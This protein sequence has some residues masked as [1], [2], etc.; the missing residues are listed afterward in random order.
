VA[1]FI[2]VRRG[3]F[4]G[5]GWLSEVGRREGCHAV[6]EDRGGRPRLTSGAPTSSGPW[7]AVASGQHTWCGN[8]GGRVAARWAPGNN[9]GWRGSKMV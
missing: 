6:R 2:T 1:R 3:E 5:E 8:R 4:G 9:S 7:P